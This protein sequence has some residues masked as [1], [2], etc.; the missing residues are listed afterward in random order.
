MKKVYLSATFMLFAGFSFGQMNLDKAISNQHIEL[1]SKNTNNTRP[2]Y[3][4]DRV[5][6]DTIIIDDFSNSSNWITSQDANGHQWNIVSSTPTNINS[7]MGT[8]A[9]TTAANGFAAFDGI[10]LLL[11]SPTPTFGAQSALLEYDSIINLSAYGAVNISFQQRYRA[12]NSDSTTLE[13]SGDNGSTWTSWRIN[14]DNPTND[15]AVQET[16]IINIS[17]VAAGS[18]T[19]KVRFR[20]SGTADQSFGAGYGWMIDDLT[21]VESYDYESEI[22][23]STF[24]SGLNGTVWASGLSY[25]SIPQAQLS[26]ISFKCNIENKGGAIQTGSYLSANITGAGTFSGVSPTSDIAILATDTFEVST[27]FTPT[28]SGVYNLLMEA[29]QTNV[30]ALPS[31]NSKLDSFEVTNNIYGRDNGIQSGSISN[32]SSNTGLDFAIGNMMEIFADDSIVNIHITITDD[33]VQNV[34]KQIYGRLFKLDAT[35]G[36]YAEVAITGNHTILNSERGTTIILPM[37]VPGSPG[38]IGSYSISAGDDLFVLAAHYGGTDPV[39]F[40]TAQ[41]VDQGTVRGLTS[42]G[43]SLVTLTNPNVVMVR[44]QLYSTDIDGDGILNVNDNCPN[45]PN[46]NQAD[47][48]SDAV[49]DVCD[50]CPTNANTNQADGDNDN[51]GDVCD[52]CSTISNP[53]QA[54]GDGDGVGDVCD[55]CSTI[56][57]PN[58]TDGDSDGVGD[59]CDNCPNDANQDQLDDDADGIGNVCDNCPDNYNPAQDNVCGVGLNKVENSIISVKQNVPNPFNGNTTVVYSLNENA[60]VTLNVIDV[61]GKVVAVYNQGNKNAGNYSILID[62]SKLTNGIYFYTFKAGE[63]SVTKR[64][65]VSK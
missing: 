7:Y 14:E 46:T 25:Y 49:G 39:R 5:Q 18:S 56:S 63:Y 38:L 54:D 26:A 34:G 20:W 27:T 55:N 3:S 31:N 65:V 19:V 45:T 41:P 17:A 64:M 33:S 2:S 21:I 15:P 48:D 23:A 12:F 22:Q 36:L 24:V 29:N 62:G 10:S 44:L 51:V 32:F 52:N 57:N 6:G 59:L 53:N 16:V 61:A 11:A 37:E 60:N 47:G 43:T 40:A 42:G 9:S 4:S 30:D 13:V 1:P 28:N 58:Q 50:N 35:T 8:M